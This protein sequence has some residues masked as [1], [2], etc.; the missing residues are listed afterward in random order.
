ML[1]TIKSYYYKYLFWKGE[2]QI[3]TSKKRSQ[4]LR[5]KGVKFDEIT[6]AHVVD[7]YSKLK[8]WKGSSNKDSRSKVARILADSVGGVE[9]VSDAI[10][11]VIV[12]TRLHKDLALVVENFIENTGLKVQLFHGTDNLDFILSSKIKKLIDN[13]MVEL[14]LLPCSSLTENFYNSLFLNVDFWKKIKG[15]GKILI[16]Q[17]DSL[18]CSDSDF[19]LSDFMCYDYIGP[20][21][22]DRLRPNGV[23]LDGGVGGF[24]LRD[25]DKSVDCLK[26]FPEDNWEGGE[27]NYFAFHVE[28]I[29][30]KVGNKEN[31][32][33]FCT[34]NDFIHR[35]VG[36]HQ[37]TNLNE[38]DKK[39]FLQYCPESKI[40]F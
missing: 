17:T 21:W 26:R 25:Y 10:F 24:S 35:S 40:L 9:I 16:F 39:N 34:Q 22:H 18:V 30:G 11:G 20:K 28:L 6:P 15:R 36:A 4:V 27:D 3:S 37:L 1:N 23:V 38:L 2:W 19:N 33:K 14:T 29:G 7:I 5:S 32:S 8:A 12:E 31:C 13:S